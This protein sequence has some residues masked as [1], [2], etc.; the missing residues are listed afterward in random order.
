MAYTDPLNA[1]DYAAGTRLATARG[2]NDA[3]TIAESANEANRLRDEFMRNLGKARK[4]AV[5]GDVA[6]IAGTA[7]GLLIPGAAP[8]AGL[9]GR[10]AGNL[11]GSPSPSVTGISDLALGLVNRNKFE[12]ADT[13]I[14]N[15]INELRESRRRKYEQ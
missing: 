1:G 11:A 12:G 10:T 4:K 15:R 8:I 9:I 14:M 5:I 7:A 2:A 13:S 6:T 3:R